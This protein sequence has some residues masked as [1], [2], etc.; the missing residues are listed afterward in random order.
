VS[1]HNLKKY[2]F[3]GASAGEHT[4]NF[5]EL[6]SAGLNDMR[7]IGTLELSQHLLGDRGKQRELVSR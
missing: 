4:Y 2:T 5:D 1:L 7:A 6:M 3:F